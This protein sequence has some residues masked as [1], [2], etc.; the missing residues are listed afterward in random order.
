MWPSVRE[1]NFNLPAWLKVCSTRTF[2]VVANAVRRHGEFFCG[3]CAREMPTDDPNGG[4]TNKSVRPKSEEGCRIVDAR[5]GSR[6]DEREHGRPATRIR[7][8]G[9]ILGHRNRQSLSPRNHEWHVPPVQ[10]LLV[11]FRLLRS[12]PCR[13]GNTRRRAL[14]RRRWFVAVTQYGAASASRDQRA[15]W[16]LVRDCK[17]AAPIPAP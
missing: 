14:P 12:G 3:P 13:T 16:C 11:P 17:A 5:P 7:P 1:T 10:A 15:L 9:D 8:L 4:F 6:C 2:M